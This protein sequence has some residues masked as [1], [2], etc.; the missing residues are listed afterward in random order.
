MRSKDYAAEAAALTLIPHMLRAWE[1]ARSL[2]GHESIGFNLSDML[3]LE[4]G[5]IAESM[6][7]YDLSSNASC[8]PRRF[9]SIDRASVTSGDIRSPIPSCGASDQVNEFNTAN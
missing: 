2:N 3:K 6:G 5:P 7:S 1:S 8:S 9:T 4:P